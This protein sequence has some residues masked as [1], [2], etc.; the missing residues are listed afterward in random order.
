M[1]RSIP[2]LFRGIIAAM[3][4][5]WTKVWLFV[6]S[7]VIL[8]PGALAAENI[9]A[10]VREVVEE[11]IVQNPGQSE[12]QTIQTL[13]LELT[14]GTAAGQLISLE[15]GN[16]PVTHQE[17][18]AVGDRV[19]VYNTPET[20]EYTI[21][22]IVRRPALGWLAAIFVV[23]AL[24]VGHWQGATSL[25]GLAGSCAVVFYYT[26]PQIAVGREPIGVVI[27]SCL[28]IVPIIFILS[29]GCNK[30]T[31][32]AI[33]GTLVA[34]VLTGWLIVWFVGAA[35]LT[36]LA[37]EEAGFIVAQYG[38]LI[39]MGKLLIAVMFFDTLGVLDDVTISQAAIVEELK[40]ANSDLSAWQLYT[41]AMKL[42]RDHIASMINTLILV[43]AGASF[44]LLLLFTYSQENLATVI[45]MELIAEELV[46]TLTGSIGL[47]WAVPIT[48]ILA[49]VVNSWSHDRQNVHKSAK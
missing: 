37:S 42:G 15:S 20:D 33:A 29:H 38:D 39:K 34:M 41:Q 3:Q 24:V 47:I 8:T 16:L 28:V 19:M 30:T 32:V 43:Y 23:S 7:L 10:I 5:W 25:L 44:P 35:G 49:V 18:Y 6:V 45:N 1:P 31:W 48:T 21:V 36:G 40:K 46:R 13:K 11:K 17:K 9:E 26:L 12:P 14:S 22:D 27:A 2:G 4:R